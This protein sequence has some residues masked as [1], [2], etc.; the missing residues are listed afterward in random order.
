MFWVSVCQNKNNSEGYILFILSRS[1]Q[2]KNTGMINAQSPERSWIY[3]STTVY[4]EHDRSPR[5][6][7]GV[8]R[9]LWAMTAQVEIVRETT[10]ET[11][12]LPLLL[13]WSFLYYTVLPQQ[14]QS[15]W[16]TVRRDCSCDTPCDSSCS[17]HNRVTHGMLLTPPTGDMIHWQPLSPTTTRT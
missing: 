17:W 3:T 10:G 16:D 12:T 1:K 5:S 9:R 11:H 14:S 8:R 6:T 7:A 2:R 13:L 4:L 15:L